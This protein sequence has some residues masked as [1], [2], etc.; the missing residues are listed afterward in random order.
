MTKS[1]NSV[2]KP[3]KRGGGET[4]A[5]LFKENYKKKLEL[6]FEILVHV[7]FWEN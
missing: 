5:C 6:Y 7:L 1:I 3:S 4:R 2:S